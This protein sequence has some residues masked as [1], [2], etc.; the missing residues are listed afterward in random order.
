VMDR[1][2]H[3]TSEPLS[4]PIMHLDASDLK[5]DEELYRL[6][7]DNSLQGL[8]ILQ[9]QRIIFVN[10]AVSE[11]SGYTRDELQSLL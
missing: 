5:C 7:I 3:N 1:Q 8:L 6:L 2:T 4:N 11:V 9:D 10:K